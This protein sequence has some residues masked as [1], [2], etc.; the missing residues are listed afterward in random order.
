MK[1]NPAHGRRGQAANAAADEE[2]AELA[3]AKNDAENHVHQTRKMLE[4]HKDK[5][6]G[7]EEA[8]IKAAMR[9]TEQI[10]NKDDVTKA[11]DRRKASPSCKPLPRTSASAS[12]KRA[13]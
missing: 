6:E 1:T 12:T 9:R 11:E 3:K 2:R 10:K 5:L 13:A 4:E 7:S 8:D